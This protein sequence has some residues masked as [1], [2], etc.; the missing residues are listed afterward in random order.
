MSKRSSIY[1][2]I[3]IAL[4]AI[5]IS[6]SLTSC[7]TTRA[8]PDDEQLFAGLKKISYVN[9]EEGGH[10]DSTIAEMEYVLASAPT[11]AL[12]GSS[13]HMSPFPVRLW[14]WNA[15]SKS[16]NAFARWLTHTFGTEPK[17][18]SEVNPDLRAQVAEGELMKRGYFNSKVS[19]EEITLKNPKKA[20]ISYTVNMGPLWRLDSI[21][22]M[23]FPAVADSLIKSSASETYLHK[24]SPFSVSDLESERQR[25]ASLFQDHGYYF[26]QS[27]Y[28]SYLADTAAVPHRVQLRLALAD[29]ID[30]R[31]HRRWYIGNIDVNMR[32]E[33]TDSLDN[34]FKFRHLRFNYRGKKPPIRPGVF[35]TGLRLRH[36][37][38]YRLE[39]VERFTKHLQSTGLFSYSGIRFTPRDTSA[40][41]DT[42][43]ARIDL[44]LDKPYDFYIEANAKGKTS[45]RY[46]PELVVGFV[47]RNAFR[48][49]EK[50]DINLHGSYEW[51]TGHA[52][53]GS[54]TG[55]NSYE[56]GLDASLTFP[57]IITPWTLFTSP[58]KQ[59][60]RLTSENNTEDRRKRRRRARRRFFSNPTTVVKLS[61]NTLN[62]S[63][64]FMRNVVSAELT[65]DW[66]TSPSSHHSFSPLL[67]S[68][69]YMNERTAAFDSLLVK[70]AYL[71]VSMRDQFVPKMSYTYTYRSPSRFR[72]PITWRTTV[73]EASNLLAA[74][75][76]VFGEGWSKKDKTMFKNPFAQFVKVETKFVKQWN[77][78]EYS[79]LV[80]HVNAGVVYSYGNANSAPYYE[81]FYV[82]GANSIRAFN[83][84]SI[85]PGT[86]LRK[87]G[88]SSYIDQIGDVK[89]QL[90]LEYRMRL[91]GSLH[92]ALFLDAGNVWTLRDH[93][94]LEGC[95]FEIGSFYKQL[96][97][98]TGV[99][100][101]Y[102]LGMFV[103]RLD[104]GIGLH[105]P[106]ETGKSGF[107]NIPKFSDGHA[108]HLAVGYPF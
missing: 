63:G 55:V 38:P 93:E 82:G 61:T 47:K 49:G 29:S 13:Y 44:V 36:G 77:F 96:A 16:D 66:S 27:G 7:S 14:I 101:R 80:G 100:L 22:Y 103:I 105:V 67:L 60:E 94:E 45:G 74:G 51:Q 88:R 5:V 3:Y 12:F 48:G 8:I 99:G 34:Y 42:L 41:C 73:S 40:T 62:R 85:G 30:P 21:A 79:S 17:L 97:L 70:N 83:V 89:L 43:D 10:A 19:Y 20:K 37:R 65:Y 90:N 68:Y 53:E 18:L 35:M 84:R 54:S 75:Y 1:H 87:K 23:S 32:K 50:L 92:G 46:G 33:M 106:Y 107:Y 25:L 69:E 26:Y 59:Y 24:G 28:A 95:K 57:R 2:I 15:F 108:I 58:V 56:Y 72:N 52:S 71:Q 9:Y 31:A 86:Y 76:A 11:E 91:W 104:W 64:Y 81:Q 39:N 6:F 78:S 102:D 98:G 4:A